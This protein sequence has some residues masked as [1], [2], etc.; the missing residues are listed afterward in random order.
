MKGGFKVIIIFWTNFYYFIVFTVELWYYWYER[1][2]SM[3]KK[4][5]KVILPVILFSAV[6]SVLSYLANSSYVFDKLQKNGWIGKSI[7]IKEIQDYCLWIGIVLSAIFLSINLI[8]TK[9][10]RDS[11]L[12]QR[13]N[14]ISMNKSLLANALGSTFVSNE[15]S[16]DIRIFIPKHKYL[17]RFYDWIKNTSFPRKFIIKNISIIAEKGSTK[18]LQFEVFPNPQGLVGECY[19]TKYIIYDDKLYETNKT[20]YSL[21][22]SQIARTSDL[23]WSICCPV[24]ENQ[25]KIVAIIALDG[26]TKITIDSEKKDALRTHLSSFSQM[27][28]DSVPQLFKR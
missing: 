1:D 9:L 28:F 7:N 27:L 18:D 25:E 17:Y 10:K 22:N 19:K 21:D 2:D 13:N 12:E 24:F 8:R 4:H 15:A 23:K 26:K 5:I 20:N 14:L 6:P 16:F 3:V 11:Y